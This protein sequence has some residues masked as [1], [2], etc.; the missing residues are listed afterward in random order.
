MENSFPS[1]TELIQKYNK[2]LIHPTELETMCFKTRT[3]SKTIDISFKRQVTSKGIRYR[4]S[5][6]CAECK[7]SKMKSTYISKDYFEHYKNEYFSVNDEE[8]EDD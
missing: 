7:P 6:K 2:N 4:M 1:K 5:G 8:K 3:L